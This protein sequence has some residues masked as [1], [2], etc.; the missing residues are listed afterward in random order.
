MIRNGFSF[1]EVS[2]ANRLLDLLNE[3]FDALPRPRLSFLGRDV[4]A[5]R[6]C[7]IAG[8]YVA[9]ITALGATLLT[10]RSAAVTAVLSFVSGLSF[11]TYA[12][13]RKWLTGQERLVL[14]EQ[15]WFAL[16]C[17]ALALWLMSEPFLPY[18]D[19]VSVALCPFL[20]T[21]RIGCTLVGCCH[22]HPSSLGIIYDEACAR[23]GFPGHLV[24]IRLFP[25]PAI[26][27][28]GLLLIGACG[29]LALP[30]ANP[31]KIFAWYLLSYS[32]L[33]FGLEGL[34]GDRRLH[35]FGLSQARWMCL[36]ELG[37]AILVIDGWQRRPMIVIAA[38]L[39]A[40]LAGVLLFWLN[41]P[42][43][44]L[45]SSAHTRELRELACRQ[46]ESEARKPT[47][48]APLVHTTSAGV[49][50]AA[51]IDRSLRAPAAHISLGMPAGVSGLWRQCELAAHT[52]PSLFL[53]TAQFTDHRILH[54]LVARPLPEIDAGSENNLRLA[55]QLYG[56]IVRDSQQNDRRRKLK[57]DMVQSN[58]TVVVEPPATEDSSAIPAGFVDAA[59][60]Y[61]TLDQT[62]E[63][64]R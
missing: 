61:F 42:R 34:R 29:L 63:L 9:L 60:W 33:R 2:R 14:L 56:C 22:G 4:P 23:D 25:V 35:L 6:S 1:E 28:L 51:T 12:R 10:G 30:F 38:I 15:V 20:A 55:E 39:L 43:R 64:K 27:A 41:D 17:N 45:L 16:L 13:W 19:I 36:L 59:S 44:R 53:E 21:G 7:G 47:V 5:F 3:W 46:I 40:S 48:I 62:P 26:E 32:V 52:F 37:L 54:L 24:G 58:S 8:F 50:I 18:L 49:S 31:G 57:P 11:F